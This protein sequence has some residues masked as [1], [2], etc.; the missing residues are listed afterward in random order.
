MSLT[1]DDL[2]AIRSI[3]RDELASRPSAPAARH[4]AA[5]IA[6]RAV[7]P[8]V[9]MG[10]Y[11]ESERDEVRAVF[12]NYGRRKGEPVEGASVA[13]LEYYETGC[14]RTLDDPAKSQWHGKERALLAA[15]SAELSKH[16]VAPASASEFTGDDESPF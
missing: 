11:E 15:I 2:E 1:P 12:P 3:V 5:A 6:A 8:D 16:G 9:I 4:R 14:R 10:L 7:F 13:D